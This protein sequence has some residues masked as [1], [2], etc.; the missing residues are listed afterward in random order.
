MNHCQRIAALL[1][2]AQADNGLKTVAIAS[3]ARGEGRTTTM[4]GLALELTRTNSNRVLLVDADLCQP[5]LQ[6][7]LRIEQSPGLSDVLSGQRHKAF[8]VAVHSSLHVLLAGR[9]STEP[10]ADLGSERLRALLERCAAHY[11]WVLVDTP[12]ASLLRDEADVLGR[13]TDGVVFVIGATTPF[14]AA[15]DVMSTIGQSRIVAT[16]LNGIP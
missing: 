13:L 2:S 14:K 12:A 4:L 11:N 8:P 1:R 7:A 3:A 6:E 10:A 16:V 5:K 15:E 9:A